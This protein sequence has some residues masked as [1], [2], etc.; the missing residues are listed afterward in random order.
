[1]REDIHVYKNEAKNYIETLETFI[2][3][4]LLDLQTLIKQRVFNDVR[5]SYEKT[6]KK[7]ASSRI[8]TIIETAIK[9]GIIDIIRDYRYKFI[10]KSQ[11]IGEICEQKYHDFGFTLGHKNDNFDA[12]G[13]FQDDFKTGFLTTS[14]EVLITKIVN[15]VSNSKANK[16]SELDRNIEKY[17]KDEFEPI[18]SN[19]KEKTNSLAI[20][21]TENFFK[22]LQEPLVVFEQ[23]LQKDEKSLQNRIKTFEENEKQREYDLE[24]HKKIKRLELINKGLKS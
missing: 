16:L 17:I 19:I 15:E 8:K 22:E 2:I 11:D 13:F 20:S 9:D 6:K 18:E 12:R 4:E 1:M 5:Y 23:K 10:K 21:L 7:P 3:N 24:L 14:N